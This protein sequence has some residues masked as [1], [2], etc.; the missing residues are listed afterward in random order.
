[1][2]VR[3]NWILAGFCMVLL[4]APVA[5]GQENQPQQPEDQNQGAPP[6][7]A[8][9]APVQGTTTS[10]TPLAG[11]QYLPV[12]G[13]DLTHSYWQPRFDLFGTFDTNPL[14]SP[15]GNEKNWT[16][17]AAFDAGVDIHRIS[18]TSE[19]A[20]G[21]LGGAMHSSDNAVE[22]GIVQA[23]N[24]SDTFSFRRASIS[25]LDQLTYLPEQAFGFGG[26]GALWQPVSP[27]GTLSTAFVPGQYILGGRGQ[28]LMNAFATQATFY[29]T[30][31]SSLTLVGA[32]S[33]LHFFDSSQLDYREAIAQAG[34][35]YQISERN[36]IALL[37]TFSAVRYRNVNQSIDAH[38]PQFSF[39]R[40]VSDQLSFQISAGP[41]FAIYR[42]PTPNSS[43]LTSG[44]TNS[45]DL[46]WYLNTATTYHLRRLALGLAYSRG[47]NGGSGVLQGSIADV[48]TGSVTRQMSRTLSSGITAGYAR[49]YGLTV[50]ATPKT[51]TYGYWFTGI[52]L[53]RPIGSTLG[54][55]FSYQLQYQ[56]SN[57]AFCAGAT[58]GT[59]V[60]RNL[61]SVGIN[62][63]ERPLM[64]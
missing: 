5:P 27:A 20:L 1:M 43:P 8:Y 2:F 12:G 29:R 23:L 45:T 44:T 14:Q 60:I 61:I 4:L 19:L 31:R 53:T 11:A 51:Q 6:I 17:W 22:N 18:P 37:Y 26:L 63:R 36:T 50:Q 15:N 55:T 34:Y 48:V 52:N 28:N 3:N 42:I 46:Y 49:N 40:Q 35:N 13:T 56:S 10:S 57:A 62:W 16:T 64:L 38:T 41:Q 32:Y 7:P 25:L 54:F 30:R 59:N 47:V 9:R 21:Y 39:A 33:L 58:C 24:F